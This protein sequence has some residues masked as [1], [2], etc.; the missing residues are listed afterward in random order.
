LVDIAGIQIQKPKALPNDIQT[1]LDGA[2]NG[3]IYVSF[4]SFL[5]SSMMPPDKFKAMVD[6]FRK[7]K[8]RVL[9]KWESDHVPDLPSNVMV[10]KWLPQ[11]DVL[12]HKNIK[13]FVAHGGIFGLQEALYTAVPMI[14]YPFFGDQHLNAHKMKE[15]GIALVQS[16]KDITSESL[17]TA[18]NT[19]INN[20]TYYQ[21]IQA[22]SEI[23]RTNQNDPLDTT[24]WWIEYVIKFKGAAHL[25]SPAKNLPWFRYLQLDIAFVI[26]GVLYVIYDLAKN[27][28]SKVD[29]KKS[30]AK[31]SEVKKTETKKDEAKKDSAAKKEK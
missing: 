24:I 3:A 14:I 28:F 19:I 16:M 4:G 11:V 7:I 30:M 22:L 26:I 31:K 5:K 21:N 6:V 17:Y 2:E 15:R 1:F 29:A 12:A 9:W 25:Q 18:I 13:L 10:K 23:F 8:H 20:Q 27:L